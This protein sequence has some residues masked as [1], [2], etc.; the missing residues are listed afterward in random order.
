M[1]VATKRGFDVFQV[2][3]HTLNKESNPDQP[4]C[5]AD[6]KRHA[7]GTPGNFC[8]DLHSDMQFQTALN[9]NEV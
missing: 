9:P 4:N 6:V 8:T 3:L 7:T 1:R 5:S 2:M